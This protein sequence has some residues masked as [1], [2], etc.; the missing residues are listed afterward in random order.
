MRV[1]IYVQ[2]KTKKKEQISKPEK[3]GSQFL[4]LSKM[5]NQKAHTEADREIEG[6]T[7]CRK[8]VTTFA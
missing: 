1:D 8:S 6:G 4:T 3:K 2:K 7:V 5:D